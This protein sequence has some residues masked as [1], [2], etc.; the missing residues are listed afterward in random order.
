[1][2]LQG[3]ARGLAATLL[4]SPKIEAILTRMG[5]STP[6]VPQAHR[7][8]ALVATRVP[9]GVKRQTARFFGYTGRRVSLAFCAVQSL[10][11]LM[12]LLGDSLD[13]AQRRTNNEL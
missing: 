13:A 1:M 3:S 4:F 5:R 8:A 10:L 9:G 2:M 6:K 7:P 12:A 11:V